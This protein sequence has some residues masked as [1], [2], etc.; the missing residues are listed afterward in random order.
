MKRK[1]WLRLMICA[2]FCLGFS[3]AQAGGAGSFDQAFAKIAQE[4]KAAKDSQ[5]SGFRA[6]SKP[7]AGTVDFKIPLNK[8]RGNAATDKRCFG[9]TL[10]CEATI[11]GPGGTYNVQVG[12]SAGSKYK[13]LKLSKGKP[14]AFKLET[15]GGFSSTTFSIDIQSDNLNNNQPVQVALA[16]SY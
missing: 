11:T 3:S 9:V 13:F 15:E 6:M 16:Y 12:T 2:L 7:S 5:K 14:V 1:L 10:D 8:G 4:L